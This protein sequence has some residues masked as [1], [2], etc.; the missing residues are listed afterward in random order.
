MNLEGLK[1]RGEW[2][3]DPT[4]NMFKEYHVVSDTELFRYIKT[5]EQ[6][7]ENR[8]DITSEKLMDTYPK[9]YK[10]LLTSRKWNAISP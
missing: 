2:T 7:Y 8:E 1:A 10:V 9:K 3:E 5:K 6:N 4:K